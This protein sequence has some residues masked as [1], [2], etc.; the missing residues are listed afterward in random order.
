MKPRKHA[1]RPTIRAE[2]YGKSEQES[3]TE[4]EPGLYCCPEEGCL[5]TSQTHESMESHINFGKHEHLLERE[6]LFDKA[7][8]GYATKL[9]E[10]LSRIPTIESHRSMVN[11][12]PSKTALQVGWA[13]KTQRKAKRFNTRQ[14]AY[15]E[16][17]FR[18]GEQTGK[19]ADPSHVA[20]QMRIARDF[21]G[22]RLFSPEEFM[23]T[24]QI[25]GFFSR[26]AREG[27]DNCAEHSIDDNDNMAVEEAQ[28]YASLRNDVLSAVNIAHPVT[29]DTYN[30]CDMVAQEKLSKLKIPLLKR[31][32]EAFDIDIST[33]FKE[34]RKAPYLL[35]LGTLVGSC[36]C[37]EV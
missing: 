2:S 20:Q 6:T 10:G 18:I 21:D 11:S 3:P 9:M 15:L 27:S 36:S 17:K 8:K 4:S 1:K 26:R 13:L 34:T 12:A 30:L 22:E 37:S 16:D 25:Q 24:Q 31:M 19:K 28:A 32:C 33:A 14:K 29:F 35:A 5:Y 7:K 23:S